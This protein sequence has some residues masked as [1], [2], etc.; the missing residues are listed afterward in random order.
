MYKAYTVK[1]YEIS[2]FFGIASLREC[3]DPPLWRVMYD[4]GKIIVLYNWSV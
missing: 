4:L 2:D 3:L 1:I